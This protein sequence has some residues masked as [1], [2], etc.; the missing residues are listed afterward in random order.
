MGIA[1]CFESAESGMHI[2]FTHRVQSIA[3]ES[4]QMYNS[5]Y[6]GIHKRHIP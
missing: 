5:R 1:E 4:L 2:I 3:P 6:A